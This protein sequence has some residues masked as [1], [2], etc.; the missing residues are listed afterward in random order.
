M[1]PKTKLVEASSWTSHLIAVFND[2]DEWHDRA[3]T[4][5]AKLG[6]DE[7]VRFSSS[8]RSSSRTLPSATR[9]EASGGDVR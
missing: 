3:M 1:A 6:V 8:L 2:D 4:V 7:D 5:A 9:D